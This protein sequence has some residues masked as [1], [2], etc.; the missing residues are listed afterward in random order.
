MIVTCEECGKKYRVYPEKIVDNNANFNCKNCNH[1]IAVPDDLVQSAMD[2]LNDDMGEASFK[3]S[4]KDSAVDQLA[5]D[6]FSPDDDGDFDLSS[7]Q[8]DDD[9]SE[10][11]DFNAI[12]EDDDT[13]GTETIID[14]VPMASVSDVYQKR[15]F[16]LLGKMLMLFLVVPLVFITG[17]GLLY[18]WQINALSKLITDESTKVVSGMAEEIISDTAFSVANQVNIYLKAHLDLPKEE[19]NTNEE[20]KSI[21]VQ[22]VGKTGYTALYERPLSSTGIWRTWG[23]PN[24]KIIGINMENLKKPL[25]VNFQG[26]WDIYTGVR[27]GRTAK[28]Y[29]NWQEADGSIRAKY[30]VSTPVKGTRYIVAS[31][32]YLDEFTDDVKLLEQRAGKLSGRAQKIAIS[33]ILLTIVIIFLCVFIYARGL[34][35]QIHSLT[36]L[37]ERISVG[38]LDAELSIQ[39]NDEIGDLG[40]AI[41][42]MQDSIRLSIRRLRRRK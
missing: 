15:K 10:T 26:F 36:T 12:A 32:T 1:N 24:A 13:S 23:H 21:A 41:R 28:G 38:D 40:E 35:K 30:M 33:V 3:D 14:A 4:A 42:R 7:Q 17:A 2:S 9:M 8:F 5:N 19:F 20:F 37:A 25:G 27:S 22:K 29:Y 31:T 39:S 11:V 34:T 16:G 18:V 6:I